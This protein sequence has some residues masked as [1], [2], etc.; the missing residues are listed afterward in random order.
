MLVEKSFT[1]RLFKEANVQLMTYLI[2]AE[3]RTKLWMITAVVI[4]IVVAW[5]VTI[6]MI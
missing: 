6:S 3:R 2:L 4:A 5:V 1:L